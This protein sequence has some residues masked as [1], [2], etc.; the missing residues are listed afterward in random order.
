M[1]QILNN[2]YP[3][4][5][6]TNKKLVKKYKVQLYIS[7]FVLIFALSLLIFNWISYNKKE[8]ISKEL[9]NSINITRLYSNNAVSNSMDNTNTINNEEDPFVIGIIQ[10]EKINLNYPILSTTSKDLLMISLCRC[11]GPMPNETGNLC[12][13]GHNLVDYKFFS[14]LNELSID[15]TIKIYSLDGNLIE[16]K[17]LEM[18]EVVPTD[19]SCLDQNVGNNRVVTL[20]TCNNVNGKR[21]IVVAEEIK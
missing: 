3:N 2:N 18:Y 16:Y 21:L 14:R 11:A 4:D 6:K 9:L 1:N 20:V 19:L 15:D 17:I 7:I 12:I 10:I 13:A 5:T 8:N